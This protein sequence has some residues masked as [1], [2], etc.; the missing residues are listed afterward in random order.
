M[1]GMGAQVEEA[2]AGM[3]E[4]LEVPMSEYLEVPMSEYLEVPMSGM[5]ASVEEAYAGMGAQVEEAYAGMNEYLEVPMSEYLEVPMSG[6]GAQVEEAYAGMGAVSPAGIAQSMANR[7][8]MPGF[9][10]AVQALVRKR[11]AQGKPLDDAFYQNLGR[12]ASA[13]ARKKFDQRVAQA[14]GRPHDI[15]KEPWKAPLLR[16]SAPMYRRPVPPAAAARVPGAAE[17]IPTH[18]PQSPQGGIFVGDEGDGIF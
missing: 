18:G 8:L 9:R 10:E 11:I 5:G 12:S 6:M 14:S 16:N 13:L 7:P 3:N 2:Y 17:P 1:S 4:Y 15:P